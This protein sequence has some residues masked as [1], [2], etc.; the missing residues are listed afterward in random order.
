MSD[1]VN[2]PYSICAHTV[3]E[4]SPLDR[5]KTIASIVMDLTAM[6]MHVCWGNP[7]ESVYHTYRLEA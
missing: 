6:E 3:V 5:Q 1:H 4:D 2:Y 7:C